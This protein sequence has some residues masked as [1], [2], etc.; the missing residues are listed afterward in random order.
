MLVKVV[1]LQHCWLKEMSITS[2]YECVSNMIGR[3]GSEIFLNQITQ[4]S[5][6]KLVP[7]LENDS[8]DSVVADPPFGEQQNYDG[9]DSLPV[10]S[11]LLNKFLDTVEPKLKQNG[12]LAIFWT[13]RNVDVVIDAVKRHFTF[14]RVLSMYLPKGNARPYLGWLPRTQAIVI[15]Q[16]YV[17]GQP[18]DFHWEMSEYMREKLNESDFTRASLA[19]ALECDSRLIM[20]WTRAGDPAWCIPTPR[21]YPKLKELLKL[22]DRYDF[23]FTRE[24]ATRAYRKDFSYKHDCYVVDDK[25]EKMIHP[26]Q[27]PLSVVE[28]LVECCCPEGGVVLDGFAGSGTTALAAKNKGRNFICFEISPEFC[29]IAKSRL[30]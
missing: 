20:K 17:P 27:K 10:A 3:R 24:P 9:D 21:F 25:N 12:H 5:C 18:T 26:A 23:L 14:R 2:D 15:A 4:G 8:I 28:H 13:M 22:D 11:D 1:F 6:L 30:E 19:R 29:E 7:Q 16:K